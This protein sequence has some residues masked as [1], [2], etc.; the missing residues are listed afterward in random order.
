MVLPG[1]LHLPLVQATVSP[2][3]LIGAQ[4]C[5]PYEEGAYTGEVAT[6]AIKDYGIDYVLV[7][8][9]ERRRHFGE[10]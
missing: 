4:N 5:S 7:G 2:G 8:H 9:S 10:T 6:D 3:V 1:M